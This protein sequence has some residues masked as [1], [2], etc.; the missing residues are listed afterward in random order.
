MSRKREKSIGIENGYR[1]TGL[2][3]ISE[4]SVR[5]SDLVC[6]KFKQIRPA[7]CNR[8]GKSGVCRTGKYSRGAYEV[9]LWNFR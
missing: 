1:K 9:S 6:K 8:K 7:A 3:L 2:K 4:S 5:R